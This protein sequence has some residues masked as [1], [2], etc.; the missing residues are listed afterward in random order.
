MVE[1]GGVFLKHLILHL[2]VDDGKQ[3]TLNGTKCARSPCLTGVGAVQA[4]LEGG[5]LGKDEG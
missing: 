2:L 5:K 3:Q 4:V 1:K